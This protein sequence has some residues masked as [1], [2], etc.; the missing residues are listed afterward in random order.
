MFLD[1]L[2]GTCACRMSLPWFHFFLKNKPTSACLSLIVLLLTE[3]E[4]SY[5]NIYSYV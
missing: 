2:T 4:P 5:S 3:Y 1:E